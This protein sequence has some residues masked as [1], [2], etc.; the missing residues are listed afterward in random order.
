MR[1]SA[2]VCDSRSTSGLQ[3]AVTSRHRGVSVIGVVVTLLC[4]AII[5]GLGIQAAH[6]AREEARQSTCRF[7]LRQLGVALH[8]Y[9]EAFGQFPYGCVGDSKL[10]PQK[11][12]SWYPHLRPFMGKYF[13]PPLDYSK[14]AD[15]PENWP[16]KYKYV[17]GDYEAIHTLRAPQSIVCPSF[18]F[19]PEPGDQALA[20]YV[21][22]SGLGKDSPRLPAKHPR[23]GTW[24]Y[25]RQTRLEDI[26][27]GMSFTVLCIETAADNGYWFL[28]GP[29]TVCG[30]DMARRPYI[31]RD[32][33]FG[34]LHASGVTTLFADGSVVCLDPSTSPVVLE[35][36]STMAG[37]ESIEAEQL[38][39]GR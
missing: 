5:L 8:C 28:G 12:W 34:G 17:N 36:I 11:R 37:A 6:R 1:A 19:K 35:A 23:A 22:M 32:R 25:D 31:G 13:T 20:T 10:P 14:P 7:D 29:A 2:T 38:E 21:G 30:V 39:S 27:D 24:A 33:Q 3:R 26:S 16:F 18:P 4:L 9:H 15:S